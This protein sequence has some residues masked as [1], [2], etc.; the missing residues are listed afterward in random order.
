MLQS[1]EQQKTNLMKIPPKFSKKSK[2]AIR[3][4]GLFNRSQD[5]RGAN[6]CGEYSK[7]SYQYWTDHVC[8]IFSDIFTISFS[9]RLTQTFTCIEK[10]YLSTKHPVNMAQR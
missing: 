5:S 2:M 9:L 4:N 10:L 8:R 7:R 1:Y 6:D 3:L